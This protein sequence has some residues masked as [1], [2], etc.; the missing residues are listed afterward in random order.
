M[1]KRYTRFF[2]DK[3]Q[4]GMDEIIK[5][6]SSAQEISNKIAGFLHPIQDKSGTITPTEADKKTYQLFLKSAGRVPS[7][8]QDKVW[9]D[10]LK[11][12]FDRDAKKKGREGK[13]TDM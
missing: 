5:H 4:E 1:I 8:N 3:F 13:T 10:A 6:S 7:I 2:E 12:A 11:I 9:Q